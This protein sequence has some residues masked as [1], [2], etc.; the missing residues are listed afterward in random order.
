[1]CELLN[2]IREKYH[3]RTVTILLDNAKYQKCKP[4]Q[5]LADILYFTRYDFVQVHIFPAG[6]SYQ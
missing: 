5:E 3:D 2:K 6:E 1:V 4:V